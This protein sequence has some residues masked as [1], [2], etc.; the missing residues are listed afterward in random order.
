MQC[1]SLA[2]PLEQCLKPETA[3]DN[4]E[5]QVEASSP[6]AP[7]SIYEQPR[8][9]IVIISKN[10]SMV[11]RSPASKPQNRRQSQE[12]RAEADSAFLYHIAGHTRK[13]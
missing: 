3:A 11:I 7:Y 9:E 8:D 4:T 12:V 13:Q 2:A 1:P 6:I 10:S 5:E